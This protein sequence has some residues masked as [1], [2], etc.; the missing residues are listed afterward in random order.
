MK[1]YWQRH[2]LIDPVIA[3]TITGCLWLLPESG[4]EAYWL[5]TAQ[6]HQDILLRLLPGN[7]TLMGLII[8]TTGFLS[9]T[10]EKEE[11]S[12]VAKSSSSAQLWEILR[13]NIGWLFVSGCYCY[14]G[15]IPVRDDIPVIHPIFGTFLGISVAITLAKLVWIMRSV[16]TVKIRNAR[17]PR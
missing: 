1:R 2:L 9:S 6:D 4:F 12:P 10:L 11:F 5:V 7:L 8:A 13:Q 15:S 17:K 16:L 14:L 3:A